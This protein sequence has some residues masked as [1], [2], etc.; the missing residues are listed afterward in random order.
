MKTK[1]INT[2]FILG[3][4]LGTRLR[5]LTENTPKPLLEIGGYPIITYAMGHLR[6]VGIK[7]FIVN[8]HHCAEKYAEVFPEGNWQ[9][10]PITFRH[11]PVLL[12]TAGGIKNI[13]DLIAEDERIIV[14]N[15][16][17]ITN[18]PME[19]LIRKHFELRTSV[20]LALRST[21]PLL[22]VNVDQEGFVCDMRHILKKPGVKSC[23]FAGI[24]IVEKSFLKRLTAGKIESIVLPLV[25][26]IKENPRSVGGVIIDDGSW[27]DVGTVDEYNKLNKAGF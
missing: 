4:G 27:Y 1:Q 25:E 7:R 19:L 8:T 2:A 16:D 10:I 5:P 24:Y 21:G 13:E 9:G 12:D 20:T 14:Y 22:N 23:L 17:I 6:A 11:E 3:A 18:L 15:G 26:M